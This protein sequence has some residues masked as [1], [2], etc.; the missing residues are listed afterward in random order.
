MHKI[1]RKAKILRTMALFASIL[2]TLPMTGQNID[3]VFVYTPA[4]ILPLLD[5]DARLDLVDYANAGMEGQAENCMGGTTRLLQKNDTLISL[6]LT[7]ASQWEL[8]IRFTP[9][10]TKRYVCT[11][12]YFLS[13][14]T[15]IREIIFDENWSKQEER[16]R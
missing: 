14:G 7:P 6:Q 10:G 1:P 8:R 12:T 9:E 16:N 13:P 15:Y 5:R 4:E 2:C 11:H 3:S